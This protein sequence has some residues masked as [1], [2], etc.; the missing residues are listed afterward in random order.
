LSVKREEADYFVAMEAWF[1]RG[2][3]YSSGKTKIVFQIGILG[4]LLDQKFHTEA[5]TLEFDIGSP[6]W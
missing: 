4:G 5:D 6:E 2:A 1:K 3:H